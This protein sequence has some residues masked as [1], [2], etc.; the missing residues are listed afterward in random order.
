MIRIHDSSRA[1]LED[2]IREA[3]E[4]TP[5]EAGVKRLNLAQLLDA[6]VR[7]LDMKIRQQIRLCT[8]DDIGKWMILGCI[9]GLRTA[10]HKVDI[11]KDDAGDV[12]VLID[13]G[14][15]DP[16]AFVRNRDDVMRDLSDTL[17]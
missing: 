13:D 14:E 4:N 10:N 1:R 6:A 7:L 9:A 5:K 3:D 2:L 16:T 15:M 8:D 12:H 17:Q 11:R